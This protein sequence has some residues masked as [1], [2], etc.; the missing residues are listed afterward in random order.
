[1]YRGIKNHFQQFISSACL[2]RSIHFPYT[3]ALRLIY[4]QKQPWMT[5]KGLIQS[6]TRNLNSKFNISEIMFWPTIREPA[7]GT[8]FVGT[9]VISTRSDWAPFLSQFPR[10]CVPVSRSWCTPR[11]LQV[12]TYRTL[13]GWRLRKLPGWNGAARH[14]FKQ[15]SEVPCTVVSNWLGVLAGI[16][17]IGISMLRSKSSVGLSLSTQFRTYFRISDQSQVRLQRTL[18]Y[19]LVK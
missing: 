5:W 4:Q 17:D 13:V 16:W 12:D 19:F 18:S 8:F 7:T 3:L 10:Q 1:M 6:I 14:G 11:C 15:A 9:S 2:E